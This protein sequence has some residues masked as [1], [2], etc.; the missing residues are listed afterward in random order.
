MVENVDDE[1]MHTCT[2]ISIKVFCLVDPLLVQDFLNVHE[3]SIET[4]SI[5]SVFG[6]Q[7]VYEPTCGKLIA[8]SIVRNHKVHI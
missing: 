4:A 2:V 6:Q 1:C 5:P 7:E 3:E 8:K